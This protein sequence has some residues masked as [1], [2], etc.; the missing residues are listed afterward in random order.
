[1]ADDSDGLFEK[2]DPSSEPFVEGKP[3]GAKG[4]SDPKLPVQ[5]ESPGVDFVKAAPP[6]VELPIL[7]KGSPID[8]SEF[9]LDSSTPVGDIK[10]LFRRPHFFFQSLG[11]APG[12]S[13]WMILKA[14]VGFCFL[15]WLVGYF[16]GQR[17]MNEALESSRPYLNELVAI[18]RDKMPAFLGS[19][20]AGDDL[21]ASLAMVLVTLVQLGMILQPFFVL[22]FLLFT[23]ATAYYFLPMIGVKKPERISFGKIYIAG[24]YANWYVVLG[25]I[26]VVGGMLSTFAAMLFYVYAIKWMQKVSFFR[27]FLALYV[28]GWLFAVMALFVSLIFLMILMTG[29]NRV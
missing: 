7:P 14:I 20:F 6:V 27:S 28:L 13:G 16:N 15:S 2:E 1:M 8:E 22:F 3:S 4:S 10:M 18:I 26:P 17:E 9:D 29:L 25:L 5:Q 24:V 19:S 21:S 23:A 12:L 11:H